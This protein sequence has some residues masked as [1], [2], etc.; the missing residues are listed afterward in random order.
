M[1]LQLI[2]FCGNTRHKLENATGHGMKSIKVTVF[3]TTSSE[4]GLFIGDEGPKDPSDEEERDSDAGP[5]IVLDRRSQ[6]QKC[7]DEV[8]NNLG[9]SVRIEVLDYNDPDRFQA[10]MEILNRA[11]ES[12]GT[13]QITTPEKFTMFVNSSAPLIVVNNRIAFTGIVPPSFQ[14]ISRVRA[15]LR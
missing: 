2:V 11:L 9:N 1:Q 5:V 3:N 14:V 7:L 6:L 8:K 12:A 15:A 4:H 13:E 10:G